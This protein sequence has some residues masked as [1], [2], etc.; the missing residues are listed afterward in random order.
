MREITIVELEEVPGGA[1]QTFQSMATI[2][3]IIASGSI[4][5]TLSDEFDLS[6]YAR[7][8]IGLIGCS[9]AGSLMVLGFLSD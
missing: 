9:I 1:R 5:L 2:G 6:R 3:A 4:Y 8:A 7:A